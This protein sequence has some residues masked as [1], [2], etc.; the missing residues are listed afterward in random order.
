MGKWRD[1][2]FFRRREGGMLRCCASV[3][4]LI[5][6]PLRCQAHSPLAK[7][8]VSIHLSSN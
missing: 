3:R 7:V 6:D 2:E 4:F 8:Q 1:A 5:A